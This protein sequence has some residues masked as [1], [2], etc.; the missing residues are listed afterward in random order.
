MVLKTL[1]KGGGVV[2]I[3]FCSRL[4]A[5]AVLAAGSQLFVAREVENGA[6]LLAFLPWYKYCQHHHHLADSLGSPMFSLI[7]RRCQAF[8]FGVLKY[9]GNSTTDAVIYDV[10]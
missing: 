8:P 3:V 1:S 7:L 2:V 6:P 5:M 4:A 9:D 10:H